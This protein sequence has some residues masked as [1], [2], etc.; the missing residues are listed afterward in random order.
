MLCSLLTWV[1]SFITISPS[2]TTSVLFDLYRRMEINVLRCNLVARCRLLSFFRVPPS[3]TPS[4]DSRALQNGSAAVVPVKR[5]TL[6]KPV[7]HHLSPNRGQRALACEPQGETF[8]K[9]HPYVS[10]FYV[11]RSKARSS[12]SMLVPCFDSPFV[13][14][15]AGSTRAL[16][17]EQFVS[18]RVM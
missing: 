1:S 9:T 5:Q 15:G 16:M 13:C 14:A 2:A 11:A 4:A 17:S 18:R 8:G 6:G 3:S 10:E 12:E 7:T